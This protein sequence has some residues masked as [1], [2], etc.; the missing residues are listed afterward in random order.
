MLRNCFEL[1]NLWALTINEYVYTASS[2]LLLFRVNRRIGRCILQFYIACFLWSRLFY[3][4]EVMEENVMLRIAVQTKGRLNE[5]SMD[6]LKEAGVSVST[7]KRKFLMRAADFPAEVIF[8][9]D[10]AGSLIYI[11]KI[12]D[13]Q[14]LWLGHLNLTL[15]PCLDLGLLFYYL[16]SIPFLFSCDEDFWFLQW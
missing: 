14:F 15:S 6:L 11:L 12:F 16:C 7:E 3:F 10:I 13:F 4:N 1:L 9:R 2:P 8:L 5:Q